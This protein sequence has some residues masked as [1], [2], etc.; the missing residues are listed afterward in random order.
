MFINIRNFLLIS[1]FVKLSCAEF[2]L[3]KA[4]KDL[5]ESEIQTLIELNKHDVDS[6]DLSDRTPLHF[7]FSNK[8]TRRNCDKFC[9]ILNLFKEKNANVKAVDIYGNTV[10]DLFVK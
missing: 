3:H 1:V 10:F 6:V 2:P 7:L 8:L 4:C 9:R 5:N